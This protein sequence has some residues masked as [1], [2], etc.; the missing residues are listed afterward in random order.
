VDW[1][2]LCTG[3]S[4]NCNPNPPPA[5]AA[6]MTAVTQN[7]STTSTE[8]H[9]AT[10][11]VVTTVAAGSTVH[12]VVTVKGETGNPPPTGSVRVDWFTNNTCTGAPVATSAPVALGSGGTV[13]AQGFP[14]GPLPAG[15]NGFRAHYLGDLAYTPSDG[16]CEPLQV[17]D[18]SIRIAPASKDN[19]VGTIHVLTITANAVGGTLAA[20]QHTATASIQRGDP[21]SFVAA[22]SCTYTGGSA[23]ASCTV[24]ITSGVAGTTHVSATSDIAVNGVTITRATATDANATAGG[25]G[26]AVKNWLRSSN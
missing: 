20:G 17:V 7:G 21:G 14:Q 24:A 2:D 22:R 11:A 18:A 15:S 23:T 8:I 4:N 1:H 25:S 13:D 12:D 26:N 19:P 6:S 5:V 3:V 16:P 10:H 9:T